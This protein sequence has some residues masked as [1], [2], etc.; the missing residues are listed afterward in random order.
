MG[1]G[2]VPRMERVLGGKEYLGGKE[3]L[4]GK[5]YHV[6]KSTLK[7]KLAAARIYEDNRMEQAK[8]NVVDEMT[9]VD[10]TL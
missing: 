2:R 3:C 9:S 4:G 10:S 8:R 6:E 7:A 1:R 5:E